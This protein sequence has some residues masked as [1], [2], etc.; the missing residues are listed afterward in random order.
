MQSNPFKDYRDSYIINQH[1]KN[2]NIIAGDYSYYAGYHHGKEFDE[3]VWYMDGKEET[4]SEQLI[5]GKF[6]SIA[7]GAT[8]MMSGNCGHRYAW[9]SQYPL[10]IFAEGYDKNNNTPPKAFISKGNINIGNDVWIG[11]EALI[12]PGVSIGD[13][14]VIGTRAVVTKDVE[15]YTIVGGNPAKLIKKR[16]SDEEIDILLRMKWWNWSEG[17]IKNNLDILRSGDIQKLAEIE[18]K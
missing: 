10:D 6:C 4:H 12:M 14:A 2:P 13:G 5:I 3:C 17:K 9:I 1:V 16:F 8:F 15:P 7:S 11:A 18:L